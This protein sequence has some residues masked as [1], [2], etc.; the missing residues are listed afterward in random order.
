MERQFNLDFFAFISLLKREKW[1]IFG[2]S[3][4]FVV[5]G[6]FYTI[7]ARK[8]FT[9]SGKILPEMQGSSNLSGLSGLA[10]LA[11]INI[12]S[13]NS[14]I[15]AVRPDLYPDVIN[16]T[17][18]FL[19]LLKTTVTT[20]GGEKETFED[21][22]HTYVEDKEELEEEYIKTY[23]VK[24]EG[25]VLLSKLNERRLNDL[26]ERVYAEL[27]RKTGIISIVVKMPD[28]I[29]AAEV[30]RFSMN[31]LMNYIIN[32]RTEKNS[33]DIKY[34][35]EQLSKAK[36]KYYKDQKKKA[37]YSDEFQAPSIRLQSADM[38][39]ERINSE[40]TL[41]SGVYTDLSKK[42]EEAK[43]K[44]RQEAPVFKV[45]EPPVAPNSK[46]SPKGVIICFVSLFLG[47]TLSICL[48]L[49]KGGS[50]KDILLYK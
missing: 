48:I 29:V 21:F 17:P 34:L 46:S 4:C 13:M 16:S 50:Y 19:E 42:L 32:Y 7:F 14:N 8:E 26:R 37:V 49:F 47:V 18:F 31:Y 38:M 28:P 33:N 24:L 44:L 1:W 3:F 6:I 41:S 15:D 36:D 5:L 39:R 23:S 45:L 35:E 40:Y 30:T 11:G 10:G 2:I 43:L 9:S 12:G 27:D 20:V 22:Y 25:I